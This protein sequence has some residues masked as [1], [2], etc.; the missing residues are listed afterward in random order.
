MENIVT[1]IENST[2]L[3]HFS[4]AHNPLGDDGIQ[5]FSELK[6]D[7][8]IQF[9]IRNVQMTEVGACALG[10]C[11]KLNNSLQSLEISNNNIK[12]SGLTKILNAL[13][14]T[15]IRLIASDCNLT[16]DGAEKICEAL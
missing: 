3:T 14:S 16:C 13:P 6:F 11:L 4:I 2:N 12:D 5:L 7:Y 8:L 15:L 10:A 9:N 1:F